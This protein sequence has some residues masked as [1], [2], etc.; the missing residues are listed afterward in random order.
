M[1]YILMFIVFLLIAFISLLPVILIGKYVYKKDI[2]KEPRKL[3]IKL[4]FFGVLSV[5]P[6]FLFSNSIWNF[7]FPNPDTFFSMFLY[8]F[9]GVGLI[10]E[11]SKFLPAYFVGIRSKYFDD[12]YDAILYTTFTALCFAGFENIWYVLNGGLKTALLRFFTA[13]PGHASD[14]VIMGYFIGLAY[15]YKNNNNNKMF[16]LNM[17]FS[18]FI[19]SF[20][21]G[22]YDFGLFYGIEKFN[23]FSI[24]MSLI[25]SISLIIYAVV[26]IKSVSCKNEKINSSILKTEYE[27]LKLFFVGIVILVLMFCFSK[28]TL[29][30]KFNM[31]AIG[32]CVN[33]V[34]ESINIKVNSYEEIIVLDER[35]LKINLSIENISDSYVQLDLSNFV[36]FDDTTSDS[37]EQSDVNF[38]NKLSN[39]INVGEKKEGYLYFEVNKK[40][41]DDSKLALIYN[42]SKEYTIVLMDSVEDFFK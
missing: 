32:D 4:I 21:H 11:I 17:F 40:I 30:D 27:G 38:N 2:D 22:I 36:L 5:I 37:F 29:L 12:I 9:I 41:D 35:Y 10:E 25:L 8:Y 28:V 31:F 16:K 13:V 18:I 3:I 34:E 24:A 6:V 14:G 33:V 19:P 7:L 1:T 23:L 20:F 42:S 39:N 26:K 15:K